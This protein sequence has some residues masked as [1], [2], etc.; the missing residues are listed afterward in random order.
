MDHKSPTK[1][2]HAVPGVLRNPHRHPRVCKG[3][4][5]DFRGP[6]QKPMGKRG[7]PATSGWH[8]LL[9]AAGGKQPAASNKR[10]AAGGRRLA[11]DHPGGRLAGEPPHPPSNEKSETR[12]LSLPLSPHQTE[13]F[14]CFDC[15]H[16][17]NHTRSGHR[18][19][20]RM[21]LRNQQAKGAE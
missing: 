8:W 18:S 9:V 11:A 20:G 6:S 17:I 16:A 5:Q 15:M 4:P 10:P 7:Q 14:S 13:Y 12:V 1:I 2:P 21:T 19:G 3:T